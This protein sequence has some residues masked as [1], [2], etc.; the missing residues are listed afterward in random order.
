[1]KIKSLGILV[2]FW[3]GYKQI[4]FGQQD[5]LFTQYAFNQ[6]VLNPAVAGTHQGI[7][8]TAMS[9]LQWAGFQGA[10][11]T[12]I[13]SAHT[14]L[15]PGNMGLGLT[16]FH[17]RIGVSRQNEFSALYSYQ[18]KFQESIL[19]FGA[20]FVLGS[21]KADYTDVDLGGIIDPNFAG[22]DFTDFGANF[23][24]GIYYYAEKFYLGFSIPH[25]TMNK[26]EV[27]NSDAIF[28]RRRI[29]Y[30]LGGYVFDLNENFQ[31]KPYFN[32]RIPAG[33]PIQIDI[34]ASLIY[35]KRIYLGL[36][37]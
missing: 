11:E 9:R 5:P 24:T 32:M 3:L 26:F 34:N 25:L 4:S 6:V 33:S 12:H 1:M 15:K 13:F 27:N 36:G 16:F 37:I 2:L 31:V 20:R 10:P 7:S 23:G 35:Q 14:P 21:F 29:Y 18:I 19:S 30:L 22:N 8:L 28:T 17:D